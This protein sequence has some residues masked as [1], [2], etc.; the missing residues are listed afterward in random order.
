MDTFIICCKI[1]SNG[2][3]FT[4]KHHYNF[5]G[6]S[7]NKKIW[8]QSKVFALSQQHTDNILIFFCKFM[9]TTRVPYSVRIINIFQVILLYTRNR[10]I[11]HTKLSVMLFKSTINKNVPVVL[12][13]LLDLIGLLNL[14]GLLDLI[15]L[16]NLIRLLH[17][18][19]LLDLIG[20]L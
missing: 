6:R 19:G 12:N 11:K 2:T 16:L 18:I 7:L 5:L 17:L 4:I 9:S 13:V 15:R 1:I 3:L 10:L 20:L 8:Q 14:I